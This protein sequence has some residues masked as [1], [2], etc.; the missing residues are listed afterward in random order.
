[1]LFEKKV[2]NDSRLA[3]EQFIRKLFLEKMYLKSLNKNI[4]LFSRKSCQE[5]F[6]FSYIQF[7]FI[8]TIQREALLK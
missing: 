8:L 1:M 2:E 5:F 3:P 6:R 4:Y 7:C